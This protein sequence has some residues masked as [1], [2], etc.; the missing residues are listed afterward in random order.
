MKLIHTADLHLGNKMH[1]I[2]RDIEYTD[3]FKWLKETIVQENADTLV[4]AGDVYDTVNPPIEAR[5]KFNRFLASLLDTDCKNIIIVGGNHDSG[6]LLDADKDLMEALNIHVIGS[7][8]NCSIEDAV[9]KLF[10][11][12]GNLVGICAAIPYIKDMELKTYCDVD[13]STEKYGNMGIKNVYDKALEVAKSMGSNL[14]VPIIATG[15]LYAAD[16]EGKYADLQYQMSHD[17][18][19]RDL[20]VVGNLGSINATSFSEEYDYV[21]LG[22]IHYTSKVADKEKIRYSGSP[23][24]MGFD[25]ADRPH[26]VL[27]V[28]CLPD[29]ETVV[30]KIMVPIS[31]HFKRVEGDCTELKAQILNL[32]E[33]YNDAL[34]IYVEARYKSKDSSE[35][36]QMLDSLKYPDRIEVV[37]RKVVKTSNPADIQLEKRT[38]SEMRNLDP[39]EIFRK[40]IM[41]ML[42]IKGKTREEQELLNNYLSY[43]LDAF[44]KVQIMGDSN[45]NI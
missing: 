24:V 27:S 23:F 19:V 45:E 11:K 31:C 15:H 9:F 18:G 10:D 16:L 44:H 26:H 35:V 32:E 36:N 38:M 41:Q 12:E 17:D 14:P 25:E 29:K 1:D 28:E 8:S 3:F 30:K 34:K 42:E 6:A 5:K 39:A 33:Q 2:N 40:R 7:L 13:T 43:F 20:D 21:A 4:I 37:S 22:H